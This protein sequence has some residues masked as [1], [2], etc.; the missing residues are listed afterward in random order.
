MNSSSFP[1]FLFLSVAAIALFSFIGVALWTTARRRERE[2]FYKSEMV[3]KIADSQGTGANAALEFIREQEK[4]AARNKREG[5]KLGGLITAA[6]G[7][8]LMVF[9]RNLVRDEPVFLAGLIPLLVGGV[10][11]AYSYFLAPKD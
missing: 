3:K 6:V 8:A 10:L 4:N 1:I 7:V 9:L 5:L 2:A 11:L